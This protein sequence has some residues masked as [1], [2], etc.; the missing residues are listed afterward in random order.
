MRRYTLPGLLVLLTLPWVAVAVV[1][2]C[3]TK[4]APLEST[5]R[6]LY[7]DRNRDGQVDQEKH[8]V[9]GAAGE[10]WELR[11]DN[12]DGHFEKKRVRWGDIDL[13]Y[14]PPVPTGVPLE[15]SI[16][17]ENRPESGI[18]HEARLHEKVDPH[19]H[20]TL[21]QVLGGSMQSVT[22]RYFSDRWTD[23]EQ[24]RDYLTGLLADDRTE[25]YTF[26]IWS[27]DVG[28]PDIECLL[29][30]KNRAQGRLLLCDAAA[31]VRDD[32]GKWWF[33]SLF[34]YFHRNHPKG[35]RSLADPAPNRP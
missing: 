25:T 27:Q 16:S 20:G 3:A 14:C 22:V 2:G 35:D 34:D 15:P 11:D 32:A 1:P 4:A 12:Y 8:L 24:V 17:F 13:S 18:P 26:Q 9:P 19:S 33:V 29:T 10:D 7:Y 6:V 28:V 31:C 30:F 23:E 21:A 5:E